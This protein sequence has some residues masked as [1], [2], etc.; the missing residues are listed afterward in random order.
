MAII[1]K[2]FGVASGAALGGALALTP[3]AVA[4]NDEAPSPVMLLGQVGSG[5]VASPVV[6]L[7]GHQWSDSGGNV[8][9]KIERPLSA[10]EQ[11]AYV[12]KVLNISVTDLAELL[13]VTRPT[14]YAWTQGGEPRDE[15]LES[16]HRI[17]QR[18]DE[19]EKYGLAGVGKLLK[20]P[21]KNGSTLL[22]MIER[23]EPIDTA[24][25]ELAAVS[26]LEQRQRAM[27]KG[28][29]VRMSAA[30]AA[31]HQSMPGYLSET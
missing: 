14:V 18:A 1:D 21:L 28:G 13:K 20:R 19:V 31:A 7:A 22:Q 30:E 26:R 4:F 5:G 12:R 17:A 29:K 11:L 10:I 9:V 23:H 24:L 15:H 25:R 6:V 27:P 2:F 8:S 16:L 3:A